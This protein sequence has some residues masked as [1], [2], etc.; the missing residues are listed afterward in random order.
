MQ[1]TTRWYS[2]VSWLTFAPY[3]RH[4][5]STRLAARVAQRTR[6]ESGSFDRLNHRIP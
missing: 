3:A 5:P 4:G 6:T 1:Q 2:L